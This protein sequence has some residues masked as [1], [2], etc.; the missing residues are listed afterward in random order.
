ML[1]ENLIDPAQQATQIVL[2]AIWA[3]LLFGGWLFGKLNADGSHRMPTWTRLGSSVALVIAAWL[4]ASAGSWNSVTV[5]IALGMTLGCLGDCFMARVFPVPSFVLT[6]MSAFGLGHIFYISG[7][8]LFSNETLP[9]IATVRWGAW[10]VCWLFAAGAWYGV[11]L[12]GQKATPLHYAALPYALL[13]A[14]TTGSALGMALVEPGFIGLALGAALFLLSDLLLA[15]QLFNGLHFRM[16]GD[17][18]WLLY[19]P[20]QALI[21]FSVYAMLTLVR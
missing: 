13:L 10:V 5:L 20:A 8:I 7:L 3:M 6:G 14:T 4:W 17:V 12:R 2:L 21:I 18:V 1:F 11:V 9:T 19:G 15:A 16:I